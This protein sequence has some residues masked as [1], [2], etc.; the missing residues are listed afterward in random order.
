[1]VFGNETKWIKE[2]TGQVIQFIEKAT[3]ECGSSHN[4]TWKKRMMYAI[5]LSA[6]LYSEHLLDRTAF[7]EWYI[8]LIESPNLDLLPLSLLMSSI[9]WKDLLCVRRTARRFAEALLGKAHMVC[10][11]HALCPLMVS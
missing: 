2:W 9:Y 10:N 5:R 6:Q 4:A 11:S 7:L 3:L 1:M 8:S